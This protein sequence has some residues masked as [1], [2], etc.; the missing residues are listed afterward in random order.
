MAHD[1]E[2]RNTAGEQGAH[3]AHDEAEAVKG[4]AAIPEL[5][6]VDC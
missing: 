4:N 6:L 1:Q 3:A 5:G 2:D